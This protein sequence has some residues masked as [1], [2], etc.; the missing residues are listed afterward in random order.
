MSTLYTRSREPR[1]GVPQ[2]SVLCRREPAEILERGGALACGTAVP[3]LSQMS[4]CVR[5]RDR[6]VC[7]M[8]LRRL[9]AAGLVLLSLGLTLDAHG[10][11]QDSAERYFA[12]HVIDE[13]TGRGVPLVE[14]STTSNVR[15]VTDSNGLVAFDEPGL[16]DNGEVWFS[17]NSHGYEYPADGFG[18]RGVRLKPT[19]GGEATIRLKR[20][21][22]A[23]RLYRVTGQGIYADT[24]R[25][26]REPPIAEPVLNGRVTGQ[27]S[28]QSIVYQ[29][30]LFL[31]WGDT[32]QAGYPLGLFE[33]SG[34][35]ADLPGDGG[36]HPD[37]GMN[38]HY[39]VDEKTGF[40]R[41]MAPLPEEGLVWIDS[42]MTVP[43]ESGR[44]RLVCH[45]T[46]LAS[47]TEPLERGLMVFNDE[48][49]TFERLA[50]VELETKRGPGGHAFRVDAGGTEY[51]YFPKPY[52]DV[53][54]KA[55]WKS[56]LDA[57]AYEAFTPLPPGGRFAGA[58]TRLDRDGE[59]KLIWAW[60]KADPVSPSE[61]RELVEAGLMT[62]EESP[63]RLAD[64]RSGREILLHGSSIAWSD[65]RNKWIL[66]GLEAGG[67]SSLLGE[68]WY[69][70][71][72][73]PEG[74]WTAAVKIVSHDDYSFY[75]PRHHP[76]LDQDG[77]RYIYF[78]GT[79]TMAFSGTKTPTPRYDYN[80]V[81]YRLDL[82]DERLR[83]EP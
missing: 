57:E 74:P 65:F 36:L 67:E 42:L 4:G 32:N 52:P 16:M 55:D 46:R 26:G 62:R 69:A 3:R 21:N 12:I 14:L 81:M 63:F 35:T 41:P 45:F 11:V 64:A 38:L 49:D 39:F 54:V 44:E 79:Y 24:V 2:G 80:Q 66:I 7:G 20:L 34:A 50:P 71:A 22:I 76:M 60:K 82:A 48:T 83:A 18:F 78:E 15:F 72:E 61:Q 31:M 30:K 9:C 53:R 68:I 59:G 58:D 1:H 6:Y 73:R 23:E 10:G 47:L 43:D 5:R 51:I 56:L 19:A 75:N 13:A 70:E 8:L 40:S 33:M 25:L 27:D 17:V 28:V 29:G 77:G 37:V